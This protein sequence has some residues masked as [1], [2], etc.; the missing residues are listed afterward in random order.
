MAGKQRYTIEQ[1]EQAL[2]DSRGLLS[3][4]A[5]RLGCDRATMYN[6]AARYPRIQQTIDDAREQLIDSAESKLA[7]AIESKADPW[8][9]QFVLKTLGKHRGYTERTETDVTSKGEPLSAS[10]TVFILPAKDPAPDPGSP[11]EELD[12]ER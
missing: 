9:I 5:R 4:A 3:P 11:P 8:A 1:M 10:R 6:Y 2:R 7:E 12:R